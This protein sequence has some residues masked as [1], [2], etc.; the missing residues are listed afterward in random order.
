MST[1]PAW[2]PVVF[3]QGTVFRSLLN[4]HSTFYSPISSYIPTPWWAARASTNGLKW[5]KLQNIIV[6]IKINR[7][8]CIP[9]KLSFH[10]INV[11]CIKAH[12]LPLLCIYSCLP[13]KGVSIICHKD[14]W[15]DFKDMFKESVQQACLQNDMH[16]N[17]SADF[18]VPTINSYWKKW[19]E[20]T[21]EKGSYLIRLIYNCKL[22]FILWF[23]GIFKVFNILRDYFSVD[24]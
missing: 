8:T 18:Q 7:K 12:F 24:Y 19:S 9:L 2:F 14:V 16:N 6:A 23:W 5:E 3:S 22:S 11:C 20:L 4:H 10:W 15:F 13:I 1:T 21:E 17:F